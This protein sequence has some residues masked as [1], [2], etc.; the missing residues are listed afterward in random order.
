MMEVITSSMFMWLEGGGLCYTIWDLQKGTNVSYISSADHSRFGGSTFRGNTRMAIS[1]D[2]SMVALTSADGILTTHYTG[3]LI[4]S[5]EFAG[6]KI[7]Y[8][9]FHGHGYQLFM[10]I[11]DNLTLEL[12]SWIIDPLQLVPQT[13]ANQVTIPMIGKTVLAYVRKGSFRNRGLACEAN[14]SKI[15]CYVSYDPAKFKSKNTLVNTSKWSMTTQGNAMNFDPRM[16]EKCFETE[17]A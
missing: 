12:S 14:G 10:V 13:A 6:H 8:V 3:I 4:D 2:Q 17:V 11:R 1:L 16:T 15:H 9:A 5:R 7:K